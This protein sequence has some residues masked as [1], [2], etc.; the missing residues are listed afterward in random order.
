MGS[1]LNHLVQWDKVPALRKM[2]VL[3]WAA[4][5]KGIW[6]SLQNGV[7]VFQ[8]KRVSYGDKLLEAFTGKRLLIGT[9]RKSR[10]IV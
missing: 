1:K 6:P 3:E 9:R 10:E 5:R 4:L 7:G 8:R 2:E